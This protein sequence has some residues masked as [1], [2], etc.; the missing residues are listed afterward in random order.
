MRSDAVVDQRHV[1]WIVSESG[2]VGILVYS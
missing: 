1:P 2:T